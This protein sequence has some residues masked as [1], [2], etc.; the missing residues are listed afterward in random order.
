MSLTVALLRA[1]SLLAVASPM[2]L[3][4]RQ[5]GPE[6]RLMPHTTMRA[7]LAV[8]ANFGAVGLFY[9]ALFVF[10]GSGPAFLSSGPV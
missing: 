4:K 8:L 10:A 7:R 3:G 9:L 1:T 6:D 2:F 5:P